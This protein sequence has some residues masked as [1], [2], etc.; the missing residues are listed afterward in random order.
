MNPEKP[1]YRRWNPPVET[2]VPNI[3]GW[4]EDIHAAHD[5]ATRLLH[6]SRAENPDPVLLDALTTATIV[7]Y[8]RC[9]TSGI[10]KRLSINELADASPEEIEIHEKILTIRNRHIAH[11]VNEQEV[12]ALYVILDGSPEATTGAIGFSSYSSSESPLLRFEVSSLMELCEK[13][14]RWLE[15]Q[16]VEANT[17]LFPIASLLSRAELLS[18]PQDEPQPNPDI[19]ASRRQSPR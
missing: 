16:L 7:R 12:H 3:H 10:R 9:F 15:A 14:F 11:P 6:E 4:L 8:S 18:L 1:I 5:M 2:R 17:Q 13:W 19:W